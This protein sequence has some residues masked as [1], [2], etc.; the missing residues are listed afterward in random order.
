[1]LVPGAF[2]RTARFLA[3]ALTVSLAGGLAV[4]CTD[5]QAGEVRIGLV[6]PLSGVYKV[7]G[8]EMR[9]GFQLYLDSHGG[10]LGGRQVRLVTADEGDSAATALA[11]TTR[12]VKQERVSLLTGLASAASVAS[13]VPLLERSGVPL[14]GMI[15]RPRLKD[16]RGVWHT[17][18]MSEEMGAAIAPYVK[19]AVDGPV[20]A[21]GPDYQGGWD[22]LRG[23]TETFARAGGELANPDG[24]AT[25]TPWPTTTNFT[26]YFA[27]IRRSGA[28][29]VY[30]FYAGS[31][32][33]DFVK[34]YRQSDVA[35]LP[36]YAAGFL[37]EGSVLKAQGQ[38]ARGIHTGLPY[39]PDLDNA[40]NRAFVASWRA[41]H[42]ASPTFNAMVAYD[43]ALVLDR[44]IAAAGQ[45]LNYDRLRGALGGLGRIDSPRGPWQFGAKNHTP[46]QKWYL[47]QVREDGRTLSNTL[48]RTLTTLGD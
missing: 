8:T 33:V 46:V 25:F 1:M 12:L 23:F 20:Y 42:P 45:D 24:K 21:I 7:I 30:C 15:G 29:A 3:A 27:G 18:Y 32:A 34:Q 17:S 28:K 35:D 13:V 14:I 37:T 38:A 48:V 39:A 19:S 26:P 10:R 44:A 43:A 40:A 41:K 47:R 11:A 6:I 5:Q 4:G 22:Q 31:A 16:V 9:D 36:L 2:R